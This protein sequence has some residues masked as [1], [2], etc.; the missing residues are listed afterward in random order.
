MSK[1]C[2]SCGTPNDEP[3]SFCTSCGK[4]FLGVVQSTP[5]SGSTESAA[6]ITPSTTF[7]VEMTAGEHKHLLSNVTI[8]D[9]SGT[10]VCI[11]RRPSL[12]HENFEVEDTEGKVI[13]LVNRKVHLLGNSFEMSDANGAVNR[14][15]QIR[16]GH[17]RGGMPRCWVEDGSGNTL[18]TL[19]YEDMLNFDLVK[20]DGSRILRAGPSRGGGST[21]GGIGQT[22]KDLAAKRYNIELFDQSFTGFQLTG[23]FAALE[24]GLN[25]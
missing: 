11:A 8:R 5:Q 22:L 2:M 25:P 21:G 20:P 18:A 9:G 17:Q 15:I 24:I 4:P 6:T 10:V 14:V 23:T 3:A 12:L 7:T 13:G 16:S 19:Q 1:Y